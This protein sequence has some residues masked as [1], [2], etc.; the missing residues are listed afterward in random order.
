MLLSMEDLV[1][2][3]SELA[4]VGRGLLESISDAGEHLSRTSSGI[5]SSEGMAQ[6]LWS[7]K[8]DSRMWV[9]E[10]A[11]FIAGVFVRYD[12]KRKEDMMWQPVWSPEDEMW[13][14]FH[15]QTKET[16]WD[17]WQV[18]HSAEGLVWIHAETSAV[19]FSPPTRPTMR[20]ASDGV[21]GD[22][23]RRPLA[24]D[25]MHCFVRS[26][27]ERGRSRSP[28]ASM[29]WRGPKRRRVDRDTGA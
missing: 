19:M 27:S 6:A 2:E 28:G 25:G 15:L 14:W 10:M 22:A 23:R 13:Y 9:C 16:K 18:R 21:C 3:L 29:S 8:E 1:A 5:S 26:P 11:D 4:M 7:L 20:I 12:L 17:V 24:E